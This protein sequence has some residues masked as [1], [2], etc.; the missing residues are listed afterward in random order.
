MLAGSRPDSTVMC[1]FAALWHKRCLYSQVHDTVH[2]VI[3]WEKRKKSAAIILLTL[4]YTT[5][6]RFI[7]GKGTARHR[8]S[9]QMQALH[10][11]RVKSESVLFYW[12]SFK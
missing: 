6:S 5:L 3:T 11:H 8:G 12:Y 2:E 10:A 4:R 1:V 9:E 7:Q